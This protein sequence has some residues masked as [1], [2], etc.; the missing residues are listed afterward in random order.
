MQYEELMMDTSM[1]HK[2]RLFRL[3]HT[4]ETGIHSISELAEKQGMTYQKAMLLL[5]DIDEELQQ[6]A[7]TQSSILKRNGKVDTTLLHVT[8]DS[9]RYALL[10][11]AV[12]FRLITYLLEHPDKT[13]EDFCEVFDTSRSTV[14]RKLQK[15]SNYL[16]TYHLRLTYNP[17]GIKG[18]ERMIRF[19]L[20]YL[21]WLGTRGS[22]WPFA[23]D[24]AIPQQ[25]KQKVATVLPLS[26]TY[27]GEKELDYFLAVFHL[28]MTQGHHVAYSRKF[29]F[30]L[31]HN[32]AYQFDWLESE[33][34]LSGKEVQGEA[35]YLFLLGHFAPFYTESGK[36]MV[37]Q[38][39]QKFSLLDNPVLN[40][41]QK[42]LRFAEESLFH[43]QKEHFDSQ[44]L[45]GNL[46]NLSFPFYVFER[47]FPHLREFLPKD[48]HS[49][50]YRQVRERVAEFFEQQLASPQ[51]LFFQ[52]S[53]QVMIDLYTRLVLPI[54]NDLIQ[55]EPLSV[56]ITMEQNQLILSPVVQFVRSLPFIQLK[57]YFPKEDYDLL[58]T[59][60]A[61]MALKD[62]PTFFWEL[63]YGEEELTR[64]YQRLRRL[65]LEKT[66]VS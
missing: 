58:I 25:L 36:A 42:F 29:D 50:A 64:L 19:T 3:L 47:P 51:Y 20:F 44:T 14:G 46:L 65:Y 17:L 7:P 4:Y 31:K 59:S 38:T 32:P 33:Y 5:A 55:P 16:K 54:Y 10:Q 18:D 57:D 8:V 30:V 60:S 26:Q 49:H 9:Y 1:Q 34:A 13:I 56:A 21:T 62:V 12:P 53:Q 37:A 40:F 45:L 63:D 48:T 22:S 39:I 11:Q 41:N 27:F 24:I 66:R 6:I 52:D 15:L 28:R 43:F 61:M 2:F 35:S 23:L